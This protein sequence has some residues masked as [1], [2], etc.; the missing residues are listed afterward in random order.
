MAKTYC[1]C[2]GMRS[3]RTACGGNDGTRAAVQ[4]YDGSVIVGNWYDGETLKVR[5]G[6]NE[7][8]S[9]YSDSNSRD[10]VGTFDDLREALALLDDIKCG[11]ASVVRHRKA[12]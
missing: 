9:A 3:P 4:S 7:G 12:K 5:V 10:F 8:S 6:T 11:R 1:T 2:Q